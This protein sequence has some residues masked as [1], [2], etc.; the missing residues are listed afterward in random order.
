MKPPLY[1]FGWPGRVGGSETKLAATA[2]LLARD[3]AIT[4]VPNERARLGERSARGWIAAHGM[5]AAAWEDLPGNLRGW[6]LALCNIPF[7]TEGHAAQA[8]VRLWPRHRAVWRWALG[9]G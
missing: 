7:L 8:K 4:W 3:F 2:H 5:R 6:G 9:D 1:L